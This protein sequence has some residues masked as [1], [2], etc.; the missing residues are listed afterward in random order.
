MH[1]RPTPEIP[2]LLLNSTKCPS[3]ILVSTGQSVVLEDPIKPWGRNLFSPLSLF[4]SF[5]LHKNPV[6]FP[7]MVGQCNCRRTCKDREAERRGLA[8]YSFL[9]I[10][11]I[12]D[13]FIYIF[14]FTKGL[15]S[16]QLPAPLPKLTLSWFYLLSL[17]TQTW[18]L[19]MYMLFI[20]PMSAFSGIG[21]WR[22]TE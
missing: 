4:F 13:L 19:A 6:V 3:G 8:A 12:R 15:C 9:W 2:S 1:S 5:Q 14:I 22:Y 20:S 10:F 11:C 17:P 18:L 16:N 7:G 21:E